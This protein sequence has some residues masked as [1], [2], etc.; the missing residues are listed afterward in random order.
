MGICFSYV[1]YANLHYSCIFTEL[2]ALHLTWEGRFTRVPN[3]AILILVG[4]CKRSLL[5]I[6]GYVL[7]YV[8]LA[9]GGYQPTDEL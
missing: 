9:T 3:R 8:L 6:L 7:T 1:D 5:I 2:L 4:R